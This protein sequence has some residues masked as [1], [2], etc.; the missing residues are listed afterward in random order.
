MPGRIIVIG[1]SLSGIDALC[2]LVACLPAN[3]PVPIFITQHVAPHSPGMLPQILSNAGKLPAV[4][5]KN[6]QSIEPGLIYVAPP[7]RHMLIRKGYI[8]LSHGPHENHARPSVDPTFRSAAV[9]YGS[10]VVGVVLTGQLDD[11]TAGLL[12]IKDR[13]GIAIVQDP[14]E[15]TAPGM[16]LSALRHVAVDFRGTLKDIAGRLIELAKDDPPADEQPLMKLM[17]IEDRIAEGVF[18]VSDWWVLESMSKPS[19]FNC[20]D[21]MSALYE[22]DDK[23]IL[24]FRCRSGH[25]FSPLTLLSGQS[26][27]R[28]KIMSAIFSALI[29]EATLVKRM[30]SL[31]AYRQDK[32]LADGL[33]NR[34]D[35]L[36]RQAAQVCDWLHAFTGVVEPDPLLLTNEQLKQ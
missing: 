31:S 30:Q 1:A 9:T 15:A 34:A 4:H 29:E 28:E 33:L 36:T 23:R 19:G 5:P 14:A 2:E 22:I 35:V 11:G 3:F 12:A 25:G 24:R 18:N 20:P 21:C 6:A 16:P 13:G 10:A 8:A 17:E 32:P 26:E 7:D 27:T